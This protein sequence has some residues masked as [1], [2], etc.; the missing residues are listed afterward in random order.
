[1]SSQ[2]QLHEPSF[3]NKE[4]T[5]LKSCIKSGWLNPIHH[6]PYIL[7]SLTS[8]ARLCQF[9]IGPRCAGAYLIILRVVFALT[10]Q[11]KVFELAVRSADASE[12]SVKTL[13]SNRRL[14]WCNRVQMI[15]YFSCFATGHR[16]D[17][18]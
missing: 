12:N 16:S 1:M 8:N 13:R 3:N 5:I 9:E 15:T 7:L 2:I 18:R 11:A 14:T 10:S 6:G 4:I 17:L